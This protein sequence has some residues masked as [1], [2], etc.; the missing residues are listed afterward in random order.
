MKELERGL[1]Q[2][3]I[4]NIVISSQME[5]DHNHTSNNLNPT[6]ITNDVELSNF[7]TACQDLSSQSH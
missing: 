3:K 4:T 7:L 2:P 1:T 6:W 5:T